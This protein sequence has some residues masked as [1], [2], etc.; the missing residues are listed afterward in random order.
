LYHV[1]D[2]EVFGDGLPATG[3]A[4]PT[5]NGD[6]YLSINDNGAYINGLTMVTAATLSGNALD[7]D[8]GVV[9]L[10]DRTLVPATED[11]VSI[12]VAAS[13][14]TEGAEF[15]QLVA[16]LTSVQ[17]NEI[18]A[19]LI[20][21]LSGNGPFTVFAPTDAAFESLYELADVAD[22]TALLDLV[23]IETLETVLLYHVF[24]SRVFSTDLP[25]LSNNTVETLGGSITFNLND[26]TIADSDAALQLGTTDATIVDVDIFGTNGVIHVIN[27]VLLP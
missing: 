13:T 11:I 25:N 21:I 5:L 4:V 14:A 8:N 20:T 9:H 6:F 2:T 23:G 3:S 16:A 15:G 22:F 1:L 17:E 18:T 7:Y 26:L 10:I 24:D 19:S 27:E 12:A